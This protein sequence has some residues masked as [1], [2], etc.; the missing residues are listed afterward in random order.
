MTHTLRLFAALALYSASISPL[1]AGSAT[2]QLNATGTILPPPQWQ[3]GWG[4]P[5][6]NLNLDFGGQVAFKDPATNRDSTSAKARLVNAADPARIDVVRPKGCT[7]GS[8]PV[9][10]NF[11]Y[12]LVDA[13]EIQADKAIQIKPSQYYQIALRFAAVGKFGGASGRVDCSSAGTLTYSY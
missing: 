2:L 9:G 13:A 7:I 8:T 6:S 1:L 4:N 3:D 10:D 11:V 12:L 5:I